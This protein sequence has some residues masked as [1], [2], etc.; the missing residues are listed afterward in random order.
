MKHKMVLNY[1]SNLYWAT[2]KAQLAVPKDSAKPQISLPKIRRGSFRRHR[3]QS[4]SCT[5]IQFNNLK[6]EE[7]FRKLILILK[8]SRKM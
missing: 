8:N 2:S 3:Q 6:L 7:L 5:L 1:L 4:P